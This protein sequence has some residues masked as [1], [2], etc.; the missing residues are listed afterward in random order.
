MRLSS[1]FPRRVSPARAV[2]AVC[3]I[4]LLRGSTSFSL[5]ALLRPVERIFA[6]CLGRFRGPG[7]PAQEPAVHCGR[8]RRRAGH[9]QCLRR[10][11]P[12][13][14]SRV[15]HLQPGPALVTVAGVAIRV[16]AANPLLTARTAS[17][18]PAFVR[19]AVG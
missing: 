15:A 6:V 14:Q 7:C 4:P 3:A 8:S 2:S 19:L 18:R 1:C 9:T 12:T 11:P 13:D 16:D 5:P 10:C 17:G